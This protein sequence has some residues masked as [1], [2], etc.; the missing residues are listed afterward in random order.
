MEFRTARG[1]LLI[2]IL[3]LLACPLLNH[4]YKIIKSAALNCIWP[5]QKPVFSLAAWWDCSY[6]NSLTGYLNDAIGFREDMIR[7]N[8]QL[9]FSIFNKINA[10]S[11]IM[12]G[13]HNLFYLDYIEAYCGTDYAGDNYLVPELV[14]MKKVQ[15]TLERMGKLFVFVHAGNKASYYSEDLPTDIPCNSAGKTNLKNFIRIGDSLGIHQIDFNSWFVSLKGKT[16]HPLFNKQGIHWGLYGALF[17]V[18]SL[19]RYIEHNKGIRMVHP[20]WSEIE[21]SH[22]ARRSEDDMERLLNLIFPMD[23]VTYWYPKLNWDDSAGCTKPKV[24]YIGDSFGWTFMHDGILNSNTDGEYWNYFR[25]S[26]GKDF[27]HTA[28]AYEM[29][30]YNWPEAIHKADCIV[31]MYTAAQLVRTSAAFIDSAYHYYYPAK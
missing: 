14:K 11:V 1:R 23:T 13:H 2:F 26:V 12:G 20:H 19:I 4:H 28:I 7:V 29:K 8:N 10:G 27:D 17:A 22:V 21:H 6:Q 9:D 3:F 18:D 24:I 31:V 25:S 15:D 16:P 5:A 30:D